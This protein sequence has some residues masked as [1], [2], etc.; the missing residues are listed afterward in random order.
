MSNRL[1]FSSASRYS[2][3]VG[4]RN[5]GPGVFRTMKPHRARTCADAVGI[6]EHAL[7]RGTRAQVHHVERGAP[8]GR[9]PHQHARTHQYHGVVGAEKRPVGRIRDGKAT[10]NQHLGCIHLARKR[11]RNRQRHAAAKRAVR[12]II[13]RPGGNPMHALVQ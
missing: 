11:V 1:S 10:L 5:Q 6:Q 3:D 4:L 9:L 7:Q 2:H 12:R 13:G 8:G